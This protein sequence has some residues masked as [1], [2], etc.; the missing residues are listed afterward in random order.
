MRLRVGATYTGTGTDRIPSLSIL[1][2]H[3][4]TCT[5]M[6]CDES[7]GMLIRGPT[8][9]HTM[10]GTDVC[11]ASPSGDRA[12]TAQRRTLER[13]NEVAKEREIYWAR[14]ISQPSRTLPHVGNYHLPYIYTLTFYY[15]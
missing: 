2:I 14:L 4:G 5:Y 13:A 11:P 1:Y 9:L 10:C 7:E 8:G 15:V 3:T 12:T 6:I